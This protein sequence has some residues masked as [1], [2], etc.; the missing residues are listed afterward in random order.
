[1][2]DKLDIAAADALGKLTEALGNG[3]KAVGT[4]G[5][6]Y[7]P[8]VVDA[9]LW[10]VRVNGLQQIATAILI[11]VAAFA[12]HKI[13]GPLLA[14]G[15]A[16][17]QAE[18]KKPWSERDSEAGELRIAAGF[19]LRVTS[20]VGAGLSVASLLWI[21]NWIAIFEPKLWVAKKLLGL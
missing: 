15:R 8:E 13:V 9:G 6:K 17:K 7:G 20:V 11:A 3:I 16:A 21:W 2:S 14:S 5:E 18:S 10:V 19:L 4:L 12:A 1:M